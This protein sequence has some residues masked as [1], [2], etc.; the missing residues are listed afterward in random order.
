LF[1]RYVFN[2]L[3]L[4]LFVTT[5]LD[6]L[7][8]VDDVSKEKVSFRLERRMTGSAAIDELLHEVS[9]SQLLPLLPYE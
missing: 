1:P 4:E 6:R 5:A 3:W 7:Q 2:P 9:H 8:L